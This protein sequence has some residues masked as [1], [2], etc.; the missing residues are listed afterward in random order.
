MLKSLHTVTLYIAPALALVVLELTARS[1]EGIA[2]RHVRILMSVIE[3]M[4]A[5]NRD[6]LIRNRNIDVEIVERTLMLVTRQRLD[7][8]V[9]ADDVLAE[10]VQS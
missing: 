2:Q 10:L 1:S 3:R 8:D 4:S 5:M 6:L 9:T 7:Y